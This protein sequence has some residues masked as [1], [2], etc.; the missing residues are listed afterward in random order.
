MCRWVLSFATDGDLGVLV[1]FI[2]HSGCTGGKKGKPGVHTSGVPGC[3]VRG[4]MGEGIG[5]ISERFTEDTSGL[6]HPC[7]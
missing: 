3:G 5:C 7:R 2:C 6:G 1:S 4:L